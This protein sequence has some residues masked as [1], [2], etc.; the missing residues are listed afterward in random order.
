MGCCCSTPRTRGDWWDVTG[1]ISYSSNY[2]NG[3]GYSSGSNSASKRKGKYKKPKKQ[4]RFRNGDK[5][6]GSF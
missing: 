3:H 6:S 5:W 2:D 4:V 1:D